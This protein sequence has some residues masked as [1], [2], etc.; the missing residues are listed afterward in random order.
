M[1]LIGV[2]QSQGSRVITRIDAYPL[3]ERGQVY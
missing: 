3:P 2:S 1:N